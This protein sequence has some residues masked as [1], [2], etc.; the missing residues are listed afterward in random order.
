MTQLSPSTLVSNSGDQSRCTRFLDLAA[1]SD[2]SNW[3][4]QI[5]IRDLSAYKTGTF[6]GPTLPE[7]GRCPPIC[8][9]VTSFMPRLEAGPAHLCSVRLDRGLSARPGPNRLAQPY[10]AAVLRVC[11]LNVSSHQF[12]FG[13]WPA[14]HG[15]WVESLLVCL[16]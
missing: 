12:P 7:R 10:V 2:G 3:H 5:P 4:Y 15:F 11:L 1:Q 8:V 16:F 6:L 9:T 13:R 14:L